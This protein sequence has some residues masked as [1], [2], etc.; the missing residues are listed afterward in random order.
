MLTWCVDEVVLVELWLTV[1]LG[2]EVVTSVADPL[3]LTDDEEDTVVTCEDCEL[4]A[5]VTMGLLKVVDFVVLLDELGWVVTLLPCP[6][7]E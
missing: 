5:V 7:S 4:V 1:V 2:E 6:P 3:G